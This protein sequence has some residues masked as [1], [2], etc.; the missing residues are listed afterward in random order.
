MRTAVLVPG[1]WLGGWVWARLSPHLPNWHLVTPTLSGLTPDA[2]AADD[3]DLAQHVADVVEVCRTHKVRD[4]VLVGHSYA[5]LVIGGAVP[6][7]VDCVSHV[8]YLDAALP[9]AGR[10]LVSDWSASGRAAV[11]AEAAAQGDPT[12]WPVPD[13][14]GAMSVMSD[15]SAADHAWFQAHAQPH[16]IETLYQPVAKVAHPTHVVPHT[17]VVCTRDR[18]TVPEAVERL[19]RD[20]AWHVVELDTGHWP[21]ITAP[22]PLADVLRAL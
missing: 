8:V 10:S 9:T 4:A 14:L 22:R 13:D 16:P 5:G 20:A 18:P 15:F 6:Q 2:G 17:Y 11:R 12:R 21:M 3:V 7:L 19:R 1:A